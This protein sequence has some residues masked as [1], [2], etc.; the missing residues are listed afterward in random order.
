MESEPSSFSSISASQ[1]QPKVS[2]TSLLKLKLTGFGVHYD[3][4]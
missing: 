2:D 3:P 1:L 4:H